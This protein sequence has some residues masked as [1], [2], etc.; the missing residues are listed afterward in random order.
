VTKVAPWSTFLSA[1]PNNKGT[2]KKT[3]QE[4]SV[5]FDP[6]RGRFFQGQSYEVQIYKYNARVLAGWSVV[7][8]ADENIFQ[9]AL[10]YSRRC[11][12]FTALAL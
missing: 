1:Q 2:S 9:N 5:K 4:L 8:N 3:S 11:N 10:G 7:T 6:S 12:F